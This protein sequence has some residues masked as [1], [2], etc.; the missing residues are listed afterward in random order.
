MNHV[1]ATVAWLH[2]VAAS[3]PQRHAA[4][5]TDRL[6]EALALLLPRLLYWAPPRVSLEEARPRTSNRHKQP[7]REEDLR[8]NEAIDGAENKCPAIDCAKRMDLERW[9]LVKLISW[10]LL[11]CLSGHEMG[12]EETKSATGTSQSIARLLEKCRQMLAFLGPSLCPI[13]S[14]LLNKETEGESVKKKV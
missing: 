6:A 2:E 7:T 5:W 3:L 1:Q 4:R 8:E 12:E 11:A 13:H 10:Q 9:E 14:F